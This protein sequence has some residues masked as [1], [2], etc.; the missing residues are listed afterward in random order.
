[1]DVAFAC[2]ECGSTVKVRG[3]APGRQ[4]RCGFC[5]RL[6]EVPYLTRVES[7]GWRRR[8]F[9]RPWWVT[10]A[11]AA[12]GV[13]TALTVVF[14]AFRVL[15]QH[16]RKAEAQ[17]IQALVTS[18]ERHEQ[19]GQLG[20]ALIDLDAAINL[21]MQYESVR[22]SNVLALKSKRKDLAV[23]DARADLQRLR[24]GTGHPFRLA[25]WLNIQARIAADTD[26]AALKQT[27]QQSSLASSRRICNPAWPKPSTS[28]RRG[29]PWR[30][31]TAATPRPAF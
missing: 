26:L 9:G 4:V 25:D 12:L 23:R 7:S 20:Q 6:I 16:Q 10:W 18:S 19:Q 2:P 5:H 22:A 1:M 28:S 31:L 30:R 14:A 29:N 15:E 3:L 13:V 8:R 24:Q 11:W 21:S 17:S 27:R